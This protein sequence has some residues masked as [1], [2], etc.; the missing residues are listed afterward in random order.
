LVVNPANDRA[1]L[2]MAVACMGAEQWQEAQ[3]EFRM[4]LSHDPPPAVR[5]A[6]HAYLKQVDRRLRRWRFSGRV[7]GG[8]LTDDNVNVGPDSEDIR[9]SP[10]ILGTRTVDELEV[11]ES[12]KPVDS[13][14][15]FASA[16]LASVY[17]AGAMGGWLL[18][19]DGTAFRNWLPDA[20]EHESRFYQVASGPR[21]AATRQLVGLP[22]RFAHID[23]GGDPLVDLY[24]FSPVCVRLAGDQA[25]WNWITSGLVEFRDYEELNDRDGWYASLGETVRWTVANG[26]WALTAGVSASQDVPD[27]D[28]YANTGLAGRTGAEY[29]ATPKTRIYARYGYAVADYEEKEALAPEARRDRQHQASAGISRGLGEAWTVDVNH[30]Y[31]DNQSTFGLYEYERNVTTVS[32]TITF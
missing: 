32:T 7:E 13:H 25:N 11:D 20:T 3:R 28:A 1:R 18:T 8:W 19:S 6:V 12:S 22:L 9:I 24:G 23:S 15:F 5:S 14:G 30:Q 17:D 21:H 4:V 29:L 10:I 27:A 31:T 2:E 26:R 16:G